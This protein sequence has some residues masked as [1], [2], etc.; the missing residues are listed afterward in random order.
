MKYGESDFFRHLPL[1]RQFFLTDHRKIIELQARREYEGFGEFPAFVGWQY[2]RYRDELRAARRVIGVSVRCQTGGWTRFRRLTYLEPAG[3]WNELNAEVSLDLFRHQVSAEEAVRRFCERRAMGERSAAL[4][5]LLRL[6]EQ[7]LDGL[8]YV[9]EV[10]RQKL[11]F[12]RLRLP[13]LLSVFWDNVLVNH[14]MRQI[15]RALVADGGA[16]I[17]EGERALERI[18]RM[19]ELAPAAGAPVK[20]LEFQR[21]TFEILA[22][23]RRYYF[24]DYGPAVRDELLALRDGYR[25]RHPDRHYAVHLDFHAIR[26]RSAHVRRLLDLLLRRQRGYR[27]VDRLVTLRFLGLFY[28]ALG[29]L[30]RRF[31]PEM[32]RR[33]AMGIETILR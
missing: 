23:A 21:D 19:I 14:G 12:R 31:V 9:E 15:L 18:A 6:S 13:P 30:T 25:A 24:A 32:A 8:L 11:F 27:L 22:A 5:E 1:N 26:L 4:V 28:R 29:P 17:E 20:D 3:F 7:A 2:E 10:A 16:H 33:T